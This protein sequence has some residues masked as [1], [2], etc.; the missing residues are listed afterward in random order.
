MNHSRRQFLSTAAAAASTLSAIGCAGPYV[1]SYGHRSSYATQI[2]MP[3]NQ[4][5]VY[6]WVD[7][8]LQNVRDQRLPP[9]RAA[10]VHTPFPWPPGFSPPTGLPGAYDEPFGIGP[11]PRGADPEVAYGVAFATA[12]AEAFQHPFLFERL[13]FLNRFPGSEAKSLGVEWGRTVGLRVL[14][15]RTND[16]SEPSEVNY[17]L[18]RY[19]RRTDSLRWRPTGPFYAASPG[20]A[21]AS[22]DRGLFPGHGHIAPW[23]MT[24]S[25][26]FRIADFHD[27]ASPEFA[28]ANST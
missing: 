23:T 20:P 10:Y 27:P 25:S 17:Y 5:T 2:L 7:A 4:N 9:P 15:M 26:Q 24:R 11:G 13:S 16:G 22:F 8:A 12:A 6:D 1:A 21:F 28:D 3:E 18:G 14:K 19:P